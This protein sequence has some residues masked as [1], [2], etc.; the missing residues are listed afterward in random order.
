MKYIKNFINLNNINKI[1]EPFCGS[2]SFSLY[3]YNK[4]NFR[5][6][7]IIN[8]IDT[9]LINFYKDI[10][11]N[12]SEKYFKNFQK[13]LKN[14]DSKQHYKNKK[15]NSKYS[16][17]EYFYYMNANSRFTSSIKEM[18]RRC[19]NRGY[20]KTTKK[21][22]DF[23]QDSNI[24]LYNKDYKKII[25][26]Y[27]DNPNVLIYIDPPYFDS[28]NSYYAPYCKK[29]M[30]SGDIY[31]NTIIFIEILNY[32]THSKANIICSMNSNAITKYLYHDFIKHKYKKIY[33]TN[34]RKEDQLILSNI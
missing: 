19:E 3:C 22:D 6:K 1:I 32:L 2:C 24:I 26:K 15:Y 25:D 4:M 9:L 8:D 16:L 29:K 5:G 27:M 23:F 7:I 20:D 21:I 28:Y 34:K 31:D 30:G 17:Q 14:T 11:K 10:K 13:I 33:Q 12:G 18:K